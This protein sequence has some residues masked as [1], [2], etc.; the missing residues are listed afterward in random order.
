MFHKI[1]LKIGKEVSIPLSKKK[2]ELQILSIAVWNF[3]NC[4]KSDP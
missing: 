3:H 2:C 4:L 1:S